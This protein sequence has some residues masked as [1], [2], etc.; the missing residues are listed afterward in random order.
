METNIENN[1]TLVTG[2]SSGLGKRLALEFAKRNHQLFLVSLPDTGLPL[3][4][5]EIMQQYRVNVQYF[6]I[7][8]TKPKAPK[9]VFKYAEK[10]NLPVNVLVNNAGVGYNGKTESLTPKLI[11]D[12]ILLNI[13]TSTLLIFLF[14]PKLKTYKKAYILNVSSFSA[15]VPLP[16]KGVYAATKTFL[17]FFTRALKN[18]LRES[19]ISITTVYP[20]GIRSERALE[21]VRN[22]HL[23]ARVSSLSPEYVAKVA[24]KNLYKGNS[25]VIPG[26]VTK[27][28]YLLGSVMPQGLMVRIAGFFFQRTT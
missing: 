2:A 8:L 10:N 7:D 16:Y 14:L 25:F 5:E 26:M 6:E 9:K 17:L 15:F 12:M 28:Y 18:E 19:G 13:R 27:F 3:L 1:Y 21:N 20:S 11:D 22:S 24:V 23:I 4:A